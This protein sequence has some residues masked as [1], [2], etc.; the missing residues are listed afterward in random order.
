TFAGGLATSLGVIT[1]RYRWEWFGSWAVAFG[2]VTYAVMSWNSVITESTG[3]GPRAMFITGFA[4][5]TY[6]RALFLRRVDQQAQNRR[7]R[8]VADG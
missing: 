7:R 8:E 2:F 6:A 4:L 3:H 1:G 5:I